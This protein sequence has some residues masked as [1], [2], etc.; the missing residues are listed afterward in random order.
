MIPIRP[1][2]AYAFRLMVLV[3]CG[4]L[5]A[6]AAFGQQAG[7]QARDLRR[8]RLDQEANPRLRLNTGGHT[9]VVRGL[10]FLPDSQRLC[11][12][13][14]D[15]NV[16]VWNL[17]TVFRDLRRVFLRERTIRWQVA[18]GLRGGIYAIDAAPSDGLLAIG[19][20]GAMGSTGEILLVSPLDGSL[21]GVLERHR[22]TVSSLAFSADGNWLASIDLDG[23]ATLWKRQGWQPAELD[24]PDPDT[25][26]TETARRIAAST[27]IR[28]ITI[29]AST[30]A[31][32]PRLAKTSREGS[33]EW[34]LRVV[35]LA[36]PTRSRLLETVHRG[37]VTALAASRDGRRLASA[38]LEGHLYL[39]DLQGNQP[40]R[41]LDPGAVPISLCFS[42]DGKT[43]ALGTAVRAGGK[44]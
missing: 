1:A 13:G 31:I 17:K 21:A 25:Y 43:L 34:Q 16:E 32:L 6:G 12:A 44:R 8:V 4:T 11:S 26:G 36:D 33:L 15:K 18:R 40:P 24:A 42:P 7:D 3:I 41:R 28:P 19:G 29:A 37:M 9:A 10:A 5:L 2:K 30:Q 35:D 20:Y 38:D 39:W 22:Q 23:R 27:D 14:L